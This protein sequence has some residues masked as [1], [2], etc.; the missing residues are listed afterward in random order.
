MSPSGGALRL[1]RTLLSLLENVAQSRD[2]DSATQ[3]RVSQPGQDSFPDNLISLFDSSATEAASLVLLAFAF[4][5]NSDHHTGISRM[6]VDD[7]RSEGPF[8]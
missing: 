5:A 2:R 1:T 8:L 7:T 3:G 6:G 4:L